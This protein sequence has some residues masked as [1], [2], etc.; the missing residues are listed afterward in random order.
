MDCSL[1]FSSMSLITSYSGEN[2]LQSEQLTHLTGNGA[3]GKRFDGNTFSLTNQPPLAS[4]FVSTLIISIVG[5]DV[6]D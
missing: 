3:V 5:L 1:P 6:C 2:G 4:L